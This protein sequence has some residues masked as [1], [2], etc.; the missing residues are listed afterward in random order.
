MSNISSRR[1]TGFLAATAIALGLP[2]A[3]AAN[4]G[5]ACGPMGGHEGHGRH[6]G[7]GFP[8]E[9]PPHGL[10]GIELTEAQRDKVFEIMHAQAPVMREYMKTVHKAEGDLRALANSS[11]YSDAKAQDIADVSARAM[12]AMTLARARTDRQ[13]FELLT[14]EQKKQLAARKL[15]AEPGALLPPMR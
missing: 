10:R 2:L 3:A 15:P 4:P 5:Q 12:A 9:M 11:D 13:I 7:M 8:G 14:S 6:G 1:I